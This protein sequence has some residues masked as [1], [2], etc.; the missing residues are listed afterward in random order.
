VDLEAL[1]AAGGYD[2]ALADEWLEESRQ[3]WGDV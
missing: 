2:S 3:Y 1:Q